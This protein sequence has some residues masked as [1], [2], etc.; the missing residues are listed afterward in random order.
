MFQSI[1]RGLANLFV[2]IVHAFG[3]G[4]TRPGVTKPGQHFD[5]FDFIPRRAG[6][7]GMNDGIDGFGATL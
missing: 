4:H 2:F 1:H 6:A 5:G 7:H 3:Q